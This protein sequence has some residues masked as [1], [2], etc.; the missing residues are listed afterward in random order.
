MKAVMEELAVM[1]DPV[2]LVLAEAVSQ[3]MVELL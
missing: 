2:P 3:A 1:V